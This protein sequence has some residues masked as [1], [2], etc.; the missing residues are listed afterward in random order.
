MYNVGDI[1]YKEPKSRFKMVSLTVILKLDPLTV[2][3]YCK[4]ITSGREFKI[5]NIKSLAKAINLSNDK[6]KQSVS[7]LEN[8]GFLLRVPIK[9]DKG[10]FKGYAYEVE[11]EPLPEKERSHAGV[12]KENNKDN[13][14]GQFRGTPIPGYPETPLPNNNII[15]LNNKKEE[16]N[17]SSTSPSP[18]CDYLSMEEQ[19]LKS[20]DAYQELIAMRYH[21]TKDGVKDKIT[22]FIIECRCNGM[23]MHQNSTDLKSHF[24]NWLKI[25]QN[26]NDRKS[27]KQRQDGESAT[28]RL[29]RVFGGTSS[30]HVGDTQGEHFK[31]SPFAD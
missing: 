24:N 23:E 6:V 10:K 27:N 19:E 22:D 18:V 14:V 16:K 11:S 3:I 8:E 20:D 29:I 30:E 5:Y 1:Y 21:L 15:E 7:I 9:D 28:E 2:G 31:S 26:G 13:G 17:N 25:Q 4:L 12:K